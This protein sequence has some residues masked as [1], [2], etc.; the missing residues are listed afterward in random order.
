ML[1]VEKIHLFVLEYFLILREF[2]VVVIRHFW[3]FLDVAEVESGI[4]LILLIFGLVDIGCFLIL[5]EFVE[6]ESE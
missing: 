4:V 1:I 6:V 5:F 3:L 2:P